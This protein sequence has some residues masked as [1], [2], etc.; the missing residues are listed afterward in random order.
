MG[1]RHSEFD[2]PFREWLAERMSDF[3][4]QL[5]N[6]QDPEVTFSAKVGELPRVTVQIRLVD[7]EGV[8]TREEFPIEVIENGRH[9][10]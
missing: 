8:Y 1:K 6:G 2:R 10:G 9:G 5:K 7:L 3:A 4:T